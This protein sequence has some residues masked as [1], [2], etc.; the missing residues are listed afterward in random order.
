MLSRSDNDQFFT[1]GHITSKKSVTQVKTLWQKAHTMS[2]SASSDT[3][4]ID[5]PIFEGYPVCEP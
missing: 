2:K 4:V 1:Y 3:A 5:R